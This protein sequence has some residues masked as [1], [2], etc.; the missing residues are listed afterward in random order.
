MTIFLA[1]V[2]YFG[3]SIYELGLLAY[4]LCGW[5]AH[6]AAHRLRMRLARGYEPVLAPIRGFIPSP[7]IGAASID[8]SPVILFIALSL[9]RNAVLALLMPPF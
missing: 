1:R 6:P 9:L 7:R 3:F 4:V 8:F 5:V 2:V